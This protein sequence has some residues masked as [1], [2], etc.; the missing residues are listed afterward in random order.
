M[1]SIIQG[2]ETIM[3]M[4]LPDQAIHA[5]A[6]PWVPQGERVWFKPLRFD[7]QNGRW[8]NLLKVTGGGKV[9]R[10]RHSGGQVLGYCIQGSWHYLERE[11]V[12]RPGTLVYEP[13]G[14]IHTLI[15]DDAEEMITLFLLEGVIQYLDDDDNLIYQDD[16]FTKME[17]YLT[18]CR[19][20]GIEP[21]DLR[22]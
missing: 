3:Q 21:V 16:V 14:D 8:I 17:R 7:L 11:W 10:H 13:P 6:I 15:V 4:G 18:Y 9:N 20:H 5:D 1:A 2:L 12:A 19:E 22:Y